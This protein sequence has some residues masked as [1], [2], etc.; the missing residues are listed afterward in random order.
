[1]MHTIMGLS[2]ASPAAIAISIALALTDPANAA[3]TS[4]IQDP[5]VRTCIERAIP[6][7]TL[8]QQLTVQVIDGTNATRESSGVLY[9]KRGDDGLSKV[10]FRIEKSAQYQGVAV[11]MNEVPAGREPTI[12]MYSPE[13]RRER[14]INSAALAGP[15]LG[16]D[17]SYEDFAQLQHIGTGGMVKR[18]ADTDS[19][20]HAAY[21]LETSPDPEVSSYSR[22]Q[23][24]FDKEWC[25]PMHTEFFAHN[26]KLLKEM[27]IDRATVQKLGDRWAPYRV[28]MHNHKQN[29]RT[30][31]VV[32]SADV[33]LP[34]PDSQF[35]LATLRQGR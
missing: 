14:R 30:V 23:T 29:S 1:M 9:W 16:T 7:H 34:I 35:S 32:D 10:F 25:L 28:I 19:E 24:T 3:D 2:P 18:L 20:G 5:E 6:G 26:G 4:A 17:F 21:V 15:L 12:N 27:S 31:L 11:V 8:K 13:L 22:I 33:E